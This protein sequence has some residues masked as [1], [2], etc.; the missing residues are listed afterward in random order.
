[1][2]WWCDGRGVGW[3]GVVGYWSGGVMERSGVEWSG[4][5]LGG[6]IVVWWW[7]G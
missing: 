7:S 3:G 5:R 2:E 1:M 4:G 6:S